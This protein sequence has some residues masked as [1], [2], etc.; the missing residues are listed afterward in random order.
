[1]GEIDER[2][3]A[4]LIFAVTLQALKDHQRGDSRATYWL[5]Q[6]ALAWLGVASMVR[7]PADLQR[8]L[9]NAGALVPLS[10]IH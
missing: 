5:Q 3:A 7:D 8:A 4:R 10:K 1:M 6:H 9:A 2:S